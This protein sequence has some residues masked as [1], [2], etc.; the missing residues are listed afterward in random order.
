MAMPISQR[1]SRLIL[2]VVFALSTGATL[3]M[4]H[5]L[6]PIEIY[7][8]PPLMIFHVPSRRCITLDHDPQRLRDI[9]GIAA[10]D[11]NRPSALATKISDAE[12]HSI[13]Q[14]LG[15]LMPTPNWRG[16]AVQHDGNC[17]NYALADWAPA[18]I[19]GL[20]ATALACGVLKRRLIIRRVTDGA[21]ITCG[22][23]LH[24][25]QSGKCPECGT[26]ASKPE[27]PAPN[28]EPRR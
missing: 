5:A 27:P 1:R 24:L 25:N 14:L 12:R 13:L 6:P 26:P 4:L 7:R 23:S 17:T 28:S 15:M 9:L 10:S 16:F 22:Y 3:W 19:T 20:G 11:E 18:C 8:S 21:C 2:G